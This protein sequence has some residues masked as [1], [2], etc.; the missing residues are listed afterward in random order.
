MAVITD[1]IQDMVE[2]EARRLSKSNSFVEYGD[3]LQEGLL[4][5]L[6]DSVKPDQKKAYYKK[7]AFTAMYR[8]ISKEK[9]GGV[10]INKH[11]GDRKSDDFHYQQEWIRDVKSVSLEAL[12]DE[13]P[14]VP[15]QF[16]RP[17]QAPTP[18]STKNTSVGDHITNLFLRGRI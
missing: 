2:Y 8:W 1:M 12:P 6:D 16:G 3:L 14:D 4:A 7:I 18:D 10:V 13:L 11:G 17:T 15:I 5:M 9:K